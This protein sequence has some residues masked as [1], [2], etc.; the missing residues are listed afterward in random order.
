[1]VTFVEITQSECIKDRNPLLKFRFDQ[2]LDNTG[3]PGKW[4]MSDIWWLCFRHR[5][6]I[7]LLTDWFINL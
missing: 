7:F 4:K 1:M 2:V 3:V 6:T 5:A